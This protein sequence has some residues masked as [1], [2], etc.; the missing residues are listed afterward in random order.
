[1]NQEEILAMKPGIL[2]NLLVAEKIMGHITIN[3]EILGFME[4]SVD[5][6]D[7]G[8]LWGLLSNYS[9]DIASAEQVVKTMVDLGYDDAIYWADFGKGKYTE[10]EAICKAALLAVM[11]DSEQGKK[12]NKSEEPTQGERS[13]L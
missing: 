6:K 13:V 4:R 11:D 5:P 10:S 3:D 9:G 2:L 12:Q 1:M 8:S 7:N